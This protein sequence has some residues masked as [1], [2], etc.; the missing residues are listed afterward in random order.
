MLVAPSGN[1]NPLGRLDRKMRLKLRSSGGKLTSLCAIGL[2]F[3][4]GLVGGQRVAASGNAAEWSASLAGTQFAIADLDGDRRPDLALV[5]VEREQASSTRYAIR[6]QLGEGA[7][8]YIGVRGP[9]GGLRLAVRDVN[10]DDNLD[11]ILT[12][13]LEHR[14]I[15]VLLND[16]HGK[17]RV[18]ETGT[19]SW[20]ERESESRLSEREAA[21]SDRFALAGVRAS[22][23][24]ETVARHT[25][26]CPTVHSHVEAGV[27]SVAPALDLGFTPGRSPPLIRLAVS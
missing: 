27:Q 20:F 19:Y 4:L 10:G 5:Q 15:Q 7:G 24:A 12:S 11:L 23:D 17:F 1:G 14:V 2:L 13:V 21:P 8:S 18:A 25:S 22:F 16:G 26:V 9:S 6:V 3:C